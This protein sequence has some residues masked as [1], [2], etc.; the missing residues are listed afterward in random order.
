VLEDAAPRSLAGGEPR[1]RLAEYFEGMLPP[2][3]TCPRRTV[4][5]VASNNPVPAR[6]STVGFSCAAGIRPSSSGGTEGSPGRV[7]V[8]IEVM[9][10]VIAS[11]RYHS[12]SS[13][14]PPVRIFQD[15]RVGRPV[16]SS[17]LLARRRTHPDVDV[18]FAVRMVARAVHAVGGDPDRRARLSACRRKLPP[19]WRRGPAHTLLLNWAG[20]PG[21]RHISF[22]YHLPV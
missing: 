21:G 5:D 14:S 11:G 20:L 16:A 22:G 4:W 18:R 9:W 6:W 12:S 19:M 2:P 13:S 8:G 10:Q 7:A 3:H 15:R 1:F 17:A